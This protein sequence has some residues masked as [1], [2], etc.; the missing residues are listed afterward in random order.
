MTHTEKA[1]RGDARGRAAL[2]RCGPDNAIT[3]DLALPP[4]ALAWPVF[5]GRSLF[6]LLALVLIAGT[7]VWGPWITLALACVTWNLVG[8]FG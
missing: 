2:A 8:R 3:R 7:W 6:P 5:L 1:P 4:R